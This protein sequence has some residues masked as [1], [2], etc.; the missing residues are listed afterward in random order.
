MAHP[1][2]RERA[3]NG[4]FV[5]F[6]H[7]P[8]RLL[9]SADL[10]AATGGAMVSLA[11]S[12][13]VFRLT[14]SALSIGLMLLASAAPTLLV[15][16]VAG[17]VVDRADRKRLLLACHLARV[18]VVA[19]IPL[20]MRL[21]VLW[22]YALVALTSG[23]RQFASPATESLV[24]EL[25]TED[26]LV[27]ANSWMSISSSA[28]MTLGYSVAGLLTTLLPLPAVFL[29]D[30]S[31]FAVAAACV[32]WMRVPR[33]PP[34]HASGLRAVAANLREGLGQ[35][36]GQPTLRSLFAVAGLFAV[37][38]GLFEALLLPFAV[39]AL[40][41]GSFLYGLQSGGLAVG[42]VAGSVLLSVAG[43]RL[44]EGQWIVLGLVGMGVSA[45]LFGVNEVVAV[46]L[47]LVLAIGAL[48][49]PINLARRVLIQRHTPREL[50]GRATGTFLV[51]RNTLYLVGMGA[52][53]LA[54]VVPVRALVV[55]V[56]VVM[57]A[58]GLVAAALPGL[59]QPR[60]E[61]RR[62]VRLL[63]GAAAA[64]GL[65][66]TRP[67][68]P[69]DFV[70]LAAHVLPLERVPHG[71]LRHLA[72]VT[73][74]AD[75]P[76]GTVV[77]RRGDA[78][79]AGYFVIRGRLVAGWDEEGGYRPLEMLGAGDVFGEIAALTGSPRTANVVAAEDSR[80][81]QVPAEVLRQ[82]AEEPTM[83]AL[84]RSTVDV[85]LDRMAGLAASPMQEI[86]PGALRELRTEH[87]APPAV[88]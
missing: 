85:R 25:C 3:A 55:G 63:R 48:N 87:P 38:I 20:L 36:F 88:A 24:P 11:A 35:V 21:D 56:G 44:R 17:V 54:D 66:R 41:A 77:L 79:D 18:A 57:L 64:P 4:A 29:L 26:T 65:T 59:G 32:A 19:S 9:F 82:L 70:A 68:T 2:G 58:A 42:Y 73:L 80:V 16:L 13:A 1:R 81:L 12:I 8:F 27:A 86:D 83:R 46:S 15:G 6:E 69:A 53:G 28:A 74:V 50:R 40:G 60:A 84:L 14:G 39:R 43:E 7:G 71:A 49:A 37:V 52:V 23:I 67:A 33:L 62:A 45:A 22:L 51:A 75:A 10:A 5:A 72:A 61:W 76:S 34:T 78:S 31:L 47:A 30:A